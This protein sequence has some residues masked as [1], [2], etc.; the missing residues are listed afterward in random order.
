MVDQIVLGQGLLDEQQIE[1][2]KGPQHAAIAQ[3]VSRVRVHLQGNSRKGPAHRP[4]FLQVAP[5][6]DLDLDAAVALVE[7]FPGDVDQPLRIGLNPDRHAHRHPFRLAAEQRPKRLARGLPQQVP[8]RQFQPGPRL[9]MALVALDPAP[10]FADPVDRLPDDGR[11]EESLQRVPR[12]ADGLVGVPGEGAGDALAPP[13]QAVRPE[14]QHK[15]LAVV[16]DA[17]GC[18][19]RRQQRHAD[20]AHLDALDRHHHPKVVSPCSRM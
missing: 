13:L 12:R 6:L 20:V 5:R 1:I 14:A 10:V 19:E 4:H 18:L 3:G 9:R 2:V 17:E 7:V 11:Q 16:F 8:H 15:R